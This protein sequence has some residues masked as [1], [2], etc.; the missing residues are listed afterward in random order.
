[1]GLSRPVLQTNPVRARLTIFGIERRILFRD[2]SQFSAFPGP[3]PSFPE[4]I[5][6]P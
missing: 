1:M 6:S 5:G 3:E 4:R 2:I